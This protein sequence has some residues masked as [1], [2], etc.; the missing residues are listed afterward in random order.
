MTIPVFTAGRIKHKNERADAQLQA[1]IAEY[2]HLIL[3]ALAEVDNAYQMQFSLYQQTKLIHQAQ[4][5][6]T[7]QAGAAENLFRFGDMT[8]D[9]SLRARL[10]AEDIADKQVQVR[11][12]EARNLVNLYKAL[13][14]GWQSIDE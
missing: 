8:L 6:A 13:G 7:S 2:D 5:Q 3:Q 12:E 9:R 4:T 11:L 1:A 10:N 14:G